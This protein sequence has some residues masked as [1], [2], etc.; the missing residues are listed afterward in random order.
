MSR[1]LLLIGFEPA[2]LIERL[3][4]QLVGPSANAIPERSTDALEK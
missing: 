4:E 2:R 3:P 1:P